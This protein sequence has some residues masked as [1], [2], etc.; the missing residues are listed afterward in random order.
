MLTLLGCTDGEPIEQATTTLILNATV[1]QSLNI[2]VG[3]A[4]VCHYRFTHDDPRITD[5]NHGRDIF[6]VLPDT[7]FIKNVT[8]TL[9]ADS[10]L[11]VV[12]NQ[13]GA[14]T[15]TISMEDIQGRI[16]LT[17]SGNTVIVECLDTLKGKIQLPDHP[18]KEVALLTGK[19]V[20]E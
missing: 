19:H 14:W 11:Q 2:E 18:Q 5:D 4:T 8:Y 17:R 13:S 20:F 15:G 1:N 16:Q 7:P 3:R 12:G 6:F 9:P 10:L